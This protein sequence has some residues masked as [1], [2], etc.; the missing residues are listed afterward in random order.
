MTFSVTRRAVAS[1]LIVLSSVTFG[2]ASA[3]AARVQGDT[4]PPATKKQCLRILKGNQRDLASARKAFPAL[5]QAAAAKVAARRHHAATVRS[6]H[7]AIQPQIDAIMNTNTEGLSQWD[8]DTM[9]A[10]IESLLAQQ[11]TLSLKVDTA[12]GKTDEAVFALQAVINKH[13]SDE[14][15]WPIHIKQI[16]R[17]C[18]KM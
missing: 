4:G 11:R 10:R 2:V 16:K 14:K 13:A 6:Q 1:A 7:D 12:D 18:A 8:V 15:N 17:Y 3:S 9:N 5:K